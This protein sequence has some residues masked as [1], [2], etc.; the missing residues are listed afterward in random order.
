MYYSLS[1]KIHHVI[2]KDLTNIKRCAS[3]VIIVIVKMDWVSRVQIP[4]KAI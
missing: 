1:L 2:S 4:Q 3:N